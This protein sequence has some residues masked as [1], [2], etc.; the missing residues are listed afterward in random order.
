[1]NNLAG[2]YD[3]Q[4]R[5][6]EAEPLYLQSLDIWKCQ[7]GND[8]PHVATNL[9]NLALLYES[10][11]KYS[12]AENLAKQALVICQNRLSNQHPNTQ[13]AAGLVKSLYIMRL[14]HCNKETLFGILHALAQ[15]ANLPELNN[16]T[17]LTLLERIENNP[18]LLSSIR[19]SLQQQ[20]DASDDNT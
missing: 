17:A 20:T 5:Y 2:L 1:M 8:H 18:E 10:Q 4:G 13:N 7:L 11:G 16:E 15:Q 12:E 19:E 3:S 14:L 9:N 6:N